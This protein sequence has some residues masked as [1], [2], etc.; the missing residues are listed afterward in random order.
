MHPTAWFR[1]LLGVESHIEPSGKGPE[2]FI[3]RH[4]TAGWGI[5]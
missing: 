2:D 4:G 3:Y 5:R 1:H